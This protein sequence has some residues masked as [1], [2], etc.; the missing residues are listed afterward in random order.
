MFENWNPLM[1]CLSMQVC[2]IRKF[3]LC[4]YPNSIDPKIGHDKLKRKYVKFYYKTV[5]CRLWQHVKCC[6]YS[7]FWQ[8]VNVQLKILCGFPNQGT[9]EVR[10]CF[11]EIN[12]FN[13]EAFHIFII[14][15]WQQ[16]TST[17]FILCDL[18][19]AKSTLLL[20]IF[21]L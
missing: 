16:D 21:D 5:V 19:D 7:V 3:T 14:T 6:L 9:K 11:G 2:F 10:F 20:N 12:C 1:L 13:D 18:N 17:L 8:H 4:L 15:N